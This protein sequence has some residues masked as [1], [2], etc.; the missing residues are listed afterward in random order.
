VVLAKLSRNSPR[1]RA[2]VEYLVRKGALD[3]RRL[4]ERFESELRPHPFNEE[5]ETRTLELWL[6][7]YFGK[8]R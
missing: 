5:R 8:E 1:D 6:D 2:D 3:S 7:E 4:K